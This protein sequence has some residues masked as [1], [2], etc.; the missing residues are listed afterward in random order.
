M[1]KLI[2]FYADLCPD[3]IPFKQELGRLNVEYE[4][5]NIFESMAN[6]KRFLKLRDNHSAFDM[7]KSLG[8]IGIPA[9]VLDD[10]KVILDREELQN[11]FG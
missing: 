11:V 3:T 5:V 9:L 6:F 4:E 1:T 2:L 8:N 7:P 10:E